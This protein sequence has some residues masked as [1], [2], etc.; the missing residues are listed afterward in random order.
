MDRLLANFKKNTYDYEFIE[1][2]NDAAI[3]KQSL[4]GKFVGYEVWKLRIAKKA[5]ESKLGIKVNIG[6]IIIP[7]NANWGS[8]G[9]TYKKIQD[10]RNKFKEITDNG[11]NSEKI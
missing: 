3:Y 4:N 1:S 11:R 6:D 8:Y 2:N 10:A 5:T 7:S 9:W